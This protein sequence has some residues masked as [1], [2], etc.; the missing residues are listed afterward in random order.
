MQNINIT[1]SG[2]TV[3][4]VDRNSQAIALPSSGENGELER[5]L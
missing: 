4:V 2:I 1:G 3:A 5:V